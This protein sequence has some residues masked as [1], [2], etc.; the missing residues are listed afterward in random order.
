MNIPS[1]RKLCSTLFTLTV[2]LRSMKVCFSFL[3]EHFQRAKFSLRNV[4]GLSM[5]RDYQRTAGLKSTPPQNCSGEISTVI[6]R[7]WQPFGNH[8]GPLF[9]EIIENCGHYAKAGP[10]PKNWTKN[11]YR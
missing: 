4:C 1:R 5:T 8:H 6:Q 2:I 3:G 9:I 7:S 11:T 10:K